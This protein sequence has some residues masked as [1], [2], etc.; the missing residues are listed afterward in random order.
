MRPSEVESHVAATES[1]PLVVKIME[2]DVLRECAQRLIQAAEQ[3][4]QNSLTAA[5]TGGSAGGPQNTAEGPQNTSGPA[6][7]EHRRIF[8]YRPSSG[9][10]RS[11]PGSG[12]SRGRGRRQPA[13][14]SPYFHRKNTWTRAFVRLAFNEQN[15]L[16][17]TSERIT[18]TLNGLGEKKL[19]FPCNDNAAQVHEVIMH[20]SPETPTPGRR[21]ALDS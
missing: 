13:A 6:W 7:E 1:P 2:G 19:Q 12:N 14:F 8:S 15:A 9:A 17:S 18:L 10:S 3:I 11:G 4:G 5:G 20:L 21:G 16:P